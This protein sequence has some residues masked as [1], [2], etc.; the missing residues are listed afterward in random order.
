MPE[1]VLYI[2]K[3]P[4]PDD[5]ETVEVPPTNA[6]VKVSDVELVQAAFV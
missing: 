3:V 2:V 4:D 5:A 6:P 1:V